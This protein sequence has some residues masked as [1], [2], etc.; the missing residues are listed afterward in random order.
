MADLTFTT[1]PKCHLGYLK[2]IGERK[3][4]F[5]GGKAVAGALLFGPIGVAAGALGKKKVTYVC[6]EC[7]YT[8]EK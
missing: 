7:G 3:G 6:S 5:S 2:P 1:C 8:V 4:G